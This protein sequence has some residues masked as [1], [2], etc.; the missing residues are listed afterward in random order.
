MF[1]SAV[2]V[3]VG[4]REKIRARKVQKS[5]LLQQSQKLGKDHYPELPRQDLVEI[6]APA[7]NHTLQLVSTQTEFYH[8]T[9]AFLQLLTD[10]SISLHY[11][12][13]NMHELAS[14]TIHKL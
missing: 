1:E 12:A 3:R 5:S 8:F 2:G 7:V 13:T 14:T 11:I 10:Q 9:R 4:G 6:E